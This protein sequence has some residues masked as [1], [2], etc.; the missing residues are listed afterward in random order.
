MIHLSRETRMKSSDDRYE[1]ALELTSNNSSKGA[2]RLTFDDRYRVTEGAFR[3][4][5]GS[6]A[7]RAAAKR[8]FLLREKKRLDDAVREMEERAEGKK[9]R[10]GARG[11]ELSGY[12][13]GHDWW[14]RLSRELDDAALTKSEGCR[15]G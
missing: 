8:R 14:W 9:F 5:L 12:H 7:L 1:A 6:C 4:S 13:E 10:S 15:D 3:V 2:H 11:W